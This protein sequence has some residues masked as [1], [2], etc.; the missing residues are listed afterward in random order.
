M[1]RLSD[2]LDVLERAI[3]DAL[4]SEQVRPEIAHTEIVRDSKGRV[5][6]VIK[7]ERGLVVRRRVERDTNGQIARVIEES[8]PLDAPIPSRQGNPAR[9]DP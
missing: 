5:V 4:V 8:E 3:P 9:F 7:I 6:K 1:S 2:A